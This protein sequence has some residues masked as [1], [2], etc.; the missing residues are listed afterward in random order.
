LLGMSD[1]P[2]EPVQS[3]KSGL[4]C[5]A[6][7]PQALGDVK[8]DEGLVRRI[9][10]PCSRRLVRAHGVEIVARLKQLVCLGQRLGAGHPSRLHG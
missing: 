9:R 8:V 3:R 10:A 7:T 4:L 5:M 1:E 6:K 2:I